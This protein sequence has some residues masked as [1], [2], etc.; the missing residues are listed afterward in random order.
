MKLVEAKFVKRS[1]CPCGHSMLRDEIPLGAVYHVDPARRQI[2]GL[3]CGGCNL[4]TRNL[5]MIW[6]ESA[7]TGS[8]GFLP[9][10]IFDI[11]KVQ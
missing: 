11:S 9:I 6:A 2:G 3:I 10:E 1:I 5:L 4:H 8:V 7:A